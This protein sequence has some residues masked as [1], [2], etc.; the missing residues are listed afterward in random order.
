MASPRM[1]SV[2]IGRLDTIREHAERGDPDALRITREAN[3]RAMRG[4]PKGVAAH[5][6]LEALKLHA[7]LHRGEPWACQK[8]AQL[9]KASKTGDRAAKETLA[10]MAT[11]AQ[12]G[13]GGSLFSAGPGQ[14]RVGGYGMPALSRAGVVF[15]AAS[16]QQVAELGQMIDRAILSRPQMVAYAAAAPAGPGLVSPWQQAKMDDAAARLQG[17]LT[18]TVLSAQAMPSISTARRLGL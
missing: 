3:A 15:G 13:G 12:H 16:R 2:V 10:V 4:D 18:T 17:R 6:A 11:S 14:A 1:D 5:Q 8:T 7:A 9:V